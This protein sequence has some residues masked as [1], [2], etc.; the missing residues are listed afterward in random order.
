MLPRMNTLSAII[1]GLMAIYLGYTLWKNWQRKRRRAARLAAPMPDAWVSLLN[2]NIPINQR[3]PNELREQWYGLIRIFVAEKAYQ[4]CAGQVIDD[5][6]MV[7][8]AGQACLLIL[9]RNTGIYPWLNSILV[10]PAAYLDPIS[11]Q[12]RLGESWTRGKVVLSWHH[13]VKGGCIPNDAQNVAIHEFAHQLDQEDGSADGL[14]VNHLPGNS[15]E[16]R[17]GFIASWATICEREYSGLHRHIRRGKKTLLDPYGATNPAE[18]F[19]VATETFFEKPQQMA[20]K[21]PELFQHLLDIYCVDP[22]A[23]Y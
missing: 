9:N 23:W 13:T 2:D 22:R 10:Y 1:L 17:K 4:G 18:F 19:S 8:I 21:H 14:P 3:F 12:S 16:Q 15:T 5:E 20:R 11:G 6:V 7:T